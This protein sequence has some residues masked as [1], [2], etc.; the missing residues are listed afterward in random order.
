[1]PW[2]RHC[3]DCQEKLEQGTLEEASR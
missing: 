2:T 1:V 3:I